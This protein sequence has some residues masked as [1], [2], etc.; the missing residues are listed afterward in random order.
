MQKTPSKFAKIFGSG[1]VG[2][3][4]SLVFFA[5]TF[6]LNKKIGILKIS[7]DQRMLTVIFVI[8]SLLTI[9]LIIWSVKSLP[10][11]DRGNNLHTSGAYKY[12]QHP[13]YASFL[14]VFNW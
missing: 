6:L 10:A 9:L 5:I 1:P 11:K 12:V 4:V 2:V 8:M 14:S 13:L 7:D 3:F